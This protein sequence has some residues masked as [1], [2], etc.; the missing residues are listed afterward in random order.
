MKWVISRQLSIT[1]VKSRSDKV[2]NSPITPKGTETVIKTLSLKKA[3]VQ[4]L[5]V[6]NSTRHS[7]KSLC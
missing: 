6:Q 2:T 5:L 7:K 3:Q 1:K 4:V